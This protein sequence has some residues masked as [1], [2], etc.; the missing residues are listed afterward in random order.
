MAMLQEFNLS[1]MLYAV[2]VLQQVQRECPVAMTICLYI[3]PNNL[4]NLS[5]MK[6]CMIGL[7]I[8]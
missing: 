6:I 2:T 7:L 3:V 4:K 1:K 8:T 5:M